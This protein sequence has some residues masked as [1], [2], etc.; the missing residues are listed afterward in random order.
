MFTG[1]V[2]DVGRV[3]MIHREAN[4]LR[5][6]IETERL[7]EP[8]VGASVSILGCCQTVIESGGGRFEVRSM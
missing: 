6:E 8:E 1:L 4:G 2:Q 5:L 7:P 3:T